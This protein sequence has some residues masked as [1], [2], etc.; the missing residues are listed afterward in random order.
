MANKYN[1]E[2]IGKATAL[3]LFSGLAASP[4][5]WFT[6]G[7]QGKIVF[8][9]LTQLGKWFASTGLVLL[10]VGIANVQVLSQQSNYDGAFDVAFRAIADRNGRLTLAEKKAIDDRVIAAFDRFADFGVRAVSDSGPA[11]VDNTSG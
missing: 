11:S 7:L 6:V 4:F 5:A 9:L 10:N 3:L 2:G 8:W 1:F